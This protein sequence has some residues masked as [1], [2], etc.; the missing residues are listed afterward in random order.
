M[1]S[2]LTALPGGGRPVRPSVMLRLE[3]SQARKQCPV[4]RARSGVLD[5]L[6]TVRVG[7]T[8]IPWA[9]ISYGRGWLSTGSPRILAT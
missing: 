7:Y 2:M 6:K 1:A 8:S 3:E 5:Y 9:P 4:V